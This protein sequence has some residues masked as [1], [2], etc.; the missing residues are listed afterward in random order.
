MMWNICEQKN[1]PTCISILFH[2][3]LTLAFAGHET[4][5]VVKT[6]GS[7]VMLILINRLLL[8]GVKF[9]FKR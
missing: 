6:A 3:P 7:S 2:Y 4:L 1:I 5:G 8:L 9:E